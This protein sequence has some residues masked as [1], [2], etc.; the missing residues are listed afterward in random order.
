MNT[1]STNILN[2]LLGIAPA[3]PGAVNGAASPIQSGEQPSFDLLFD[4]LLGANTKGNE[5]VD[6]FLSRFGTTDETGQAMATSSLPLFATD[7]KALMA[8]RTTV[9]GTTPHINPARIPGFSFGDNDGDADDAASPINSKVAQDSTLPTFGQSAIPSANPFAAIT[10]NTGEAFD[11]RALM[12]LMPTGP[13]AS[14]Q[15]DLNALPVDLPEGNYR[16][17]DWSV[18]DGNLN[19]QLAPADGTTDTSIRVSLPLANLQLSP[20][21]AQLVNPNGWQRLDLDGSTDQSKQ[22]LKTFEAVNLKELKIEVTGPTATRSAANPTRSMQVTLIGEN[23]GQEV[24]LKANIARNEIRARLD[25]NGKAL[26][27][28]TDNV[29]KTLGG[30]ESHRVVSA[31]TAILGNATD[32]TADGRI[33][34]NKTGSGFDLFAKSSDTASK[35]STARTDPSASLPD[36]A[37]SLNQVTL[38]QS[39][40]TAA[41]ARFTLPDNAN[42]MLKPNGQSVQLRLDPEHL[43][44]ARLSL[45]VHND[46]LRASVVVENHHARQVVEGSLDRLVQALAKADI[47]VDFINVT[48]DQHASQEQLFDQRPQWTKT[49]RSGRLFN[50]E[51]ESVPAATAVPGL[52]RNAST[53]VGAGG[54]NVLA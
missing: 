4:S 5:A 27:T 47:K 49:S 51:N 13:M 28:N 41:P 6:T 21:T 45:T 8:S 34:A 30:T 14:T 48:V 10:D 16:I 43:G 15:G 52:Y 42:A 46:H 12:A 37:K 17:L 50:L 33:L 2:L 1:A 38:N 20:E 29:M 19:L 26:S 53:Y 36:F 54:V 32:E 25:N 3:Q 7:L 11:V 44:P 18:N 24:A 23:V 39:R 35:T 22:L 40:E 9:P 31:Q